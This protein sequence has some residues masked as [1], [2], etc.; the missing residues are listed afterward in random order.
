MNLKTMTDA[1][2]VALIQEAHAE[3]ISRRLTNKPEDV[4]EPS[5][6]DPVLD[7]IK[8]QLANGAKYTQI[9]EELLVPWALSKRV[10]GMSFNGIA[11]I[12]NIT[13]VPSVIGKINSWY[14]GTIERLLNKTP[15][16]LQGE[17]RE[18]IE[19]P[20]PEAQTETDPILA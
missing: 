10:G 11:K 14:G 4:Q 12:L 5:E 8:A 15:S 9:R 13:E 2:L 6:P 1:D 3:L 16:T 19:P 18:L 20:M 17:Q 7:K